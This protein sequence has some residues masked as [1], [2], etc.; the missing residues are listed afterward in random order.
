MVIYPESFSIKPNI[1]ATIGFR[2]LFNTTSQTAVHKTLTL[3]KGNYVFCSK[4]AEE[5]VFCISNTTAAVE[6]GDGRSV[7]II[8]RS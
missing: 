5:K 1:E 8:V 2:N 4:N 7:R 3:V 6:Y